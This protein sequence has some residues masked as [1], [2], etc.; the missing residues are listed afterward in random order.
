MTAP[1]PSAPSYSRVGLIVGGGA[2]VLCIAVLIY[3]AGHRPTLDSKADQDNRE[4]VD[5]GRLTYQQTCMACHGDRLKGKPTWHKTVES[6]DQ[7]GTPLNADGVTWHLSDPRLFGA[8]KTGERFKD[9]KTKRIHAEPFDGKLSDD[10]IWAL[11]AYFKTTWTA[12]QVES[13]KE[14]TLRERAAK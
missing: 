14:T 8:I 2:M 10:K 11:I 1:S 12:R 9:G 7:A 6:Q 4:L 5:L 3:I 13:Q